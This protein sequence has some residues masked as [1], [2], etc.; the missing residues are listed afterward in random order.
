MWERGRTGAA[1]LALLGGLLPAGADEHDG[2]DTLGEIR[3]PSLAIGK[4]YSTWRQDQP[5]VVVRNDTDD[6]LVVYLE[7]ALPV[8]HELRHGALPVPDRGWVRLE[9]E[10]LVLPPRTS[11]RADVRLT[12]PYDPDLAGHTYQV[13]LWAGAKRRDGTLAIGVERHRLL[14]TVVMDYR[15]DTEIDFASLGSLPQLAM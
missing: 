11:E 6:T 14:F 5:P 7:V 4:S 15:D 10:A 8:R 13:D 9:N 12:L 1:V 2:R 3:L